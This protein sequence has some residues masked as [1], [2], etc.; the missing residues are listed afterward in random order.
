[1]IIRDF[2]DND[3][4]KFTT[5]NAIGKKFPNAEVVYQFIN[6]GNT[7]FPDGFAE[8]LRTEV[9]E[10]KNL[11]LSKEAE[12]FI[13]KKCYYFD[14]EFIV[15]LKGYHFNPGEVSIKQ[16]G[17]TL[18]VE[19]EGL[20]CRTVLW[21]VPLLAIISELYF[22]M[23]NQKPDDFESRAILKAKEFVAINAHISEFGSRRRFSFDVQNRI[24]EILKENMG[25]CL[26]G[27]SN[28]YLAMKH[29]L[30]PV[31]THPHEWFMYHGAHFGYRLA[32]SK[33]LENWVDVYQG[34]LGIALTDTYT[35]DNFFK[36]FNVELS[37]L[38]NGLR[39]DSGDPFEF[40]DKVLKHYE[41]MN[42]D[43]RSKTVVYSDSLDLE[44]VKEIKKH[45]NGRVRDLYGIGTYLT[46]D[47][48]VE[49]LNMVMKMV[50]AKPVGYTEHVP[51]V[52]LS[53]VREKNTGIKSE[54]E[55]CLNTLIRNHP[56]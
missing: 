30:S 39:W 7:P 40:T 56:N 25:N 8:A 4:Y 31:G 2:T 1:M 22:K 55:V 16:E 3:L 20:W 17:G 14:P 5:M 32:N 48:G 18:N 38:F 10:M 27:T 11:S 36:N 41:A 47:V 21:E 12:D 37:N 33:G 52:K 46:N 15:V 29:N 34:N 54:I 24:I 50:L 28:V 26:D 51:T 35:T 49:P 53:D 42:I 23:T 44:K 6:R 19:V 45:V 9:D 13:R 43:A